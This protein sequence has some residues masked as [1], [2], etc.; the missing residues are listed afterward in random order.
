[1]AEAL[2]KV[3]EKFVDTVQKGELATALEVT[4][5]SVAIEMPTIPP[6]DQRSK[7]FVEIKLL[8]ALSEL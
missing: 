1:M 6:V 5:K 4:V 3:S 8:V 7:N 2:T